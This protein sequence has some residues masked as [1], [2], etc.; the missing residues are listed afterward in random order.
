MH[1]Y[2]EKIFLILINEGEWTS[3]GCFRQNGVVAETGYR[4]LEVHAVILW[5]GEGLS[6][7]TLP[8]KD[9]IQ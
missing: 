8:V 4:M 9:N 3:I 5:S 2:K 1:N 7:I 6:V